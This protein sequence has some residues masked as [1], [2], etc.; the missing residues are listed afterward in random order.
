[1]S[2][3]ETLRSVTSAVSNLSAGRRNNVF[4]GDNSYELAQNRP[5]RRQT[6]ADGLKR[7]LTPGEGLKRRV[8]T[9]DGMKRRATPGTGLTRRQTAGD[10]MGRRLTPGDGLKRRSTPGEG[11]GA[12]KTGRKTNV[13]QL[14]FMEDI[15][16][17]RESTFDNE[18]FKKE[19]VEEEEDYDEYMATE[20]YDSFRMTL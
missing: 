10:G 15:M 17:E 14:P 13:S 5:Q 11:V 16:E 7:R 12:R 6:P 2:N 20:R 1:M 9:G 18:S 19:E 4:A 8:T 3:R